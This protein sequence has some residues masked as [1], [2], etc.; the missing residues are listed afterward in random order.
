[1]PKWRDA[2]DSNKVS[3]RIVAIVVDEAPHGK[4][5]TYIMITHIT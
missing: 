1:M 4:Y 2:P 5:N 3:G